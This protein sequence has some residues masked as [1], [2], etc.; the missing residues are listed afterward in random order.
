MQV[1]SDTDHNQ[2]VR[3]PVEVSDLLI[4]ELFNSSDNKT[5]ED[6]VFKVLL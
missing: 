1:L 6:A 4:L 5:I 3:C 2:N